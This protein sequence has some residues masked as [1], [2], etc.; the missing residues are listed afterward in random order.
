[1]RAAWGVD[2][3]TSR[4]G[5]RP[6]DMTRDARLSRYGTV[7]TTLALHSDRRLR[8]LVDDAAPLG[9]GIGGAS[10]LLDV[11]GTPVFVKRVPVT[12]ME[13][14]PEH[15][16]STANVF[17]LPAFCQ[18]GIGSPGFGAWRELA[19]HTMTTNWVPADECSAFPLMY[20]WRL[21]PDV[22]R[23]LPPELDDVERAVAYWGGAPGMRARIEGLRESSTS[24]V[25]FM[26]YVP[27][28][29]HAW[30]T[31]QVRA[32]DEAADRAITLAH[33]EL[34]AGTAF[35]NARGLIHFDA[36]ADNVLT[37]G[38]GLYF[39]D[40]GLALSS[41][42]DLSPAETDFYERHRTYDRDYTASHLVNWIIRAL[43]GYG[44]TE[45]AALVHA[46]A[47]GAAP[48]PAPPRTR[49]ILARDAPLAA[50]LTDFYG[51]LQHESRE[52]PYP[53]E[54]IQQAAMVRDAL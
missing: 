14:L 50:V 11:G 49:A 28:T 4:H 40:F 45:C 20:H 13:L 7:S 25:V 26:E 43:N 22:P 38:Q 31:E 21:L 8:R 47:R 19:V 12:D 54:A 51:T 48:P 6:P 34:A 5:S 23:S 41:A 52:T 24:L 33:R 2:S 29:L 44:P 16:R 3:V 27:L 17:G 37:D 30:L 39:A 15:V 53:L 32:G 35:M 42:F 18:Y 46:I 9:S 1:M 36:H 10:A